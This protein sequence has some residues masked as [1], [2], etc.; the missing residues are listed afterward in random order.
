MAK[1][2]ILKGEV[3]ISD[4]GLKETTKGARSLD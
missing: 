2:V 3:Q 1:K 4:K